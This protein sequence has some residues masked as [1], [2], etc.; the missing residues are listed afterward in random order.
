MTRTGE[1]PI[2]VALETR[3][4]HVEYRSERLN[5]HE[6]RIAWPSFDQSD[7]CISTSPVSFNTR[8]PLPSVFEYRYRDRLVPRRTT[9]ERE[10]RAIR[11]PQRFRE[12]RVRARQQQPLPSFDR[13]AFPQL[14]TASP[15]GV[16]G[17][18]Q[19]VGAHVEIY[20]SRVALSNGI[21]L[22]G[23][24]PAGG[25]EWER[26]E[27][28]LA[29]R[30]REDQSRAVCRNGQIRL[31]PRASGQALGAIHPFLC[32]WINGKAPDVLRIPRSSL[33]ID[34]P[35]RCRPDESPAETLARSCWT[36]SDTSG[37]VALP[38]SSGTV[39]N[40]TSSLPIVPQIEIPRPSG[41]QAA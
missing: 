34:V 9:Q 6:P 27:P 11:R 23:D 37:L 14:V 15:N 21:R 16:I 33:E 19:A 7:P 36:R 41:C 20:F 8:S 10:P 25:V 29:R 38:P 35:T 30:R 22:T 39:R 40:R 32:R 12:A 2:S 4:K 24:V 31:W 28:R 13:R 18:L 1:S 3:T 17:D 26:P 5:R